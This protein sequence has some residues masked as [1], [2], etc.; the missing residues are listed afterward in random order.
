MRKWAV[1]LSKLSDLLIRDPEI[2]VADRD[3]LRRLVQNNM[4]TARYTSPTLMNIYSL[5]IP[6]LA[7]P[8]R[9]LTVTQPLDPTSR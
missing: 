5:S 4:D 3:Y 7:P 9:N 6:L 1:E 8:P 2:T